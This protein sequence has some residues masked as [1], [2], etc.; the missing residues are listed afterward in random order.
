MISP[1]TVGQS[2]LIY[3]Y[4]KTLTIVSLC[5]ML[6]FVSWKRGG[7][8]NSRATLVSTHYNIATPLLKCRPS[9][10]ARL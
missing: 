3:I 8:A 4:N 9:P 6:Y 5:N 2:S 7:G 1:L 10:V